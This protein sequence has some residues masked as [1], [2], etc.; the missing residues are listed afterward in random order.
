MIYSPSLHYYKLHISSSHPSTLPPGQHTFYSHNS[1]CTCRR[2]ISRVVQ[3]MEENFQLTV[4]GGYKLPLPMLSIIYWTVCKLYILCVAQAYIREFTLR[5]AV[6]LFHSRGGGGGAW[7]DGRKDWFI[8]CQ[9]RIPQI[10]CITHA[11]LLLLYPRLLLIY[12]AS[13]IC[14]YVPLHNLIVFYCFYWF[15][16]IHCK[17]GW[18][19]W[20]LNESGEMVVVMAMKKL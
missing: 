11:L 8:V 6:I 12:D 18:M 10:Q 3:G 4:E 5:T 7:M 17:G 20:K 15:C 2:I 19:K 1:G 14:I 16:W 9:R 13:Y